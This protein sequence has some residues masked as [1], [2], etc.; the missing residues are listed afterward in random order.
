MTTS[1]KRFSFFL[2]PSLP[3]LFLFCQT[4]ID[5]NLNA[6]NSLVLEF[7]SI[8]FH[9]FPLSPSPLSLSPLPPLGCLTVLCLPISCLKHHEILAFKIKAKKQKISFRIFS[10]K[11]KQNTCV[12]STHPKKEEKVLILG[13]FFFFLVVE[14]LV[15]ITIL[16]DA[17]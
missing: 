17:K 1:H 11:R 2:S 10:K 15:G 14:F 4:V 13:Y 9:F 3:L 7:V 16:E 12:F 8:L 6:S 5:E